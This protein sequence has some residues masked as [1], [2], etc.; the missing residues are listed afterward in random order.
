MLK[1][2][3]IFLVVL[4][5]ATTT[6]ASNVYNLEGTLG[7]SKIYMRFEDYTDD[8]PEEEPRILDV[9]YF[10][11]SSLK[12]IVLEG[13]REGSTFTFY[14]DLDETSFKEKF[15]I[16]KD[17]KGNFSGTWQ[18]SNGKTLKVVLRPILLK[19]ITNNFDHLKLVQDYKKTNPFE[20]IRSS[21]LKFK[22]DSTSLFQGGKFRWLSETHS[23]TFGFYLDSTFS[24]KT[25]DCV[26]PRLEEILVENAMNQLTCSS[27]WEYSSGNGIE[28]SLSLN[29]LDKNLLSFT[30]FE[31]WFCGG[32]HPDFGKSCYLLDL[33]TGKNYEFEELFSFDAS[34]VV[35]DETNDNFTQY[36]D[37][38]SNFFAPKI[39][40]LLLEQELIS[41]DYN[42]ED[43][44]C[45][46]LYNSPESWTFSEWEFT[47]EGIVF[48]PSVFRAARACETETFLLP[49]SVLSKW[50]VSK[51]PYSFPSEN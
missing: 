8:Y 16:N 47:A 5:V 41:Q 42:S 29:Y 40:S 46:E 35:Y 4:F 20:Y 37:Y 14:F 21:K 19:S 48:T 38:R 49:F 26:N 27:Q 1:Y 43:D 24:Q 28:R 11:S 39:V 36:N 44:P 2:T 33:N 10:Y 15:V 22:T 30:L 12:D 23:T 45:M 7:K 9:R 50:K 34:S 3:F 25:R 17:V 13:T 32:A 31:S 6:K 51:F 18:G